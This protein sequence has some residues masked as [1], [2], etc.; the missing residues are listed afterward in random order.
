MVEVVGYLQRQLVLLFQSCEEC[1]GISGSLDAA[2][3]R[4]SAWYLAGT[5]P[6]HSAKLS[7]GKL[8]SAGMGSSEEGTNLARCEKLRG[9]LVSH[10]PRSWSRKTGFEAW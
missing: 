3:L 10:M 6:Y 2:A 8:I 4:N 5:H 1:I 9:G 7:K